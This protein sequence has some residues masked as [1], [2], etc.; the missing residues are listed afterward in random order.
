MIKYHQL[1]QQFL[2]NTLNLKKN[3]WGISTKWDLQTNSTTLCAYIHGWLWYMYMCILT[4][5]FIVFNTEAKNLSYFFFKEDYTFYTS[6]QSTLFTTCWMKH[7]SFL[8][9]LKYSSEL[10]NISDGLNNVMTKKKSLL[11]LSYF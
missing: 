10:Q 9:I 6:T 1:W 4:F 5:K 11:F 3:I 2:T 8:Q 7:Q